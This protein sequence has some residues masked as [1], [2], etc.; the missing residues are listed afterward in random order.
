[1]FLQDFRLYQWNT[2]NEK[3]WNK[4]NCHFFLNWQ[5]NCHF[6]RNWQIIN[7]FSQK[8]EV[9]IRFDFHIESQ[10]FL[11]ISMFSNKIFTL[12]S[13]AQL[14]EK[15]KI[16]HKISIFFS[17]KIDS[18]AQKLMWEKHSLL[19]PKVLHDLILSLYIKI[20]SFTQKLTL[21]A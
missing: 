19:Y 6:S 5:L 4:T 14:F 20:H 16:S 2:D 11:K 3:N 10:N 15:V 9:F 1:M 17:Q 12:T 8:I 13:R 7:T 21:F 18:F